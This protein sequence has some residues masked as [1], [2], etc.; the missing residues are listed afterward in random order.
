MSKQIAVIGAVPRGFVHSH[1]EYIEWAKQFG[2]VE[3][4]SAYADFNSEWDL[5]ILQG[6]AD[7][8]EARYKKMPP[9]IIGRGNPHQEHFDTKILPEY[10]RKRTPIFGICRGSQTLN[11]AFGGTL[12][13]LYTHPYSPNG[14][15]SIAHHMVDSDGKVI[16]VNSLHH[17]AVELL[18][19]KLEVL[20]VSCNKEGETT[21]VVEAFQHSTLPI[22]AVQYHPEKMK[23][24]KYAVEL[25][26][27]IIR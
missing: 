13:N 16:P 27:S 6:G 2:H 20:G 4:V 12:Q 14:G 18:G 25:V 15:A 10:I 24:D 11:V 3:E 26:K 7:V 9:S 21:G 23:D 5:I 22:K 1:C 17:Q 19:D 8:D